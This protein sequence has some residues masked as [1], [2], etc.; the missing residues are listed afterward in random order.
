MQ[1]TFVAVPVPMLML[2]LLPLDVVPVYIVKEPD[3]PLVPAL[4]VYET[5]KKNM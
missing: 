5:Q 1:L 3:T 2:P 4:A